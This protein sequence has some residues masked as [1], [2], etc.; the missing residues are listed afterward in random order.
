MSL[1]VREFMHTLSKHGGPQYSNRFRVTLPVRRL[2]LIEKALGYEDANGA[3][4]NV[5]CTSVDIP[6]F[7]LLTKVERKHGPRESVQM[8]SGFNVQTSTMQFVDTSNGLIRTYFEGWFDSIVDEYGH[9]DYYDNI[10]ENITITSLDKE[11]NAGISVRLLGCYPSTRGTYT[12]SNEN[13]GPLTIG[14]TFNVNNYEIVTSTE[15]KV[16]RTIN[17]ITKF[18]R[19][20]GDVTGID[21]ATSGRNLIGRIL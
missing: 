6:G 8:P 11:G 16:Q 15:G 9:V 1:N 13:Q 10:I 14:V 19:I 2:P 12:Y 21:L 17:K 7:D 3:E 4:L 18:G 20:L 5:L